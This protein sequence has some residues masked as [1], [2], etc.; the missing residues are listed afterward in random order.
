MKN[1]KIVL[2]GASI[3]LLTGCALGAKKLS[4]AEFKDIYDREIKVTAITDIKEA[5]APIS[6]KKEQRNIEPKTLV[7]ESYSIDVSKLEEFKVKDTL[8]NGLNLNYKQAATNYVT[9]EIVTSSGLKAFSDVEK[10]SLSTSYKLVNTVNDNAGELKFQ[11]IVET[12]LIKTDYLSAELDGSTGRIAAAKIII[13]DDIYGFGAETVVFDTFAMKVEQDEESTEEATDDA[14]SIVTSLAG[15]TWIL[16][17]ST[18]TYKDATVAFESNLDTT[19]SK[20][21]KIGTLTYQSVAHDLFIFEKGDGSYNFEI[22]ITETT[23]TPE[24]DQV[25]KTVAY[26]AASQ[27]DITAK[28]VPA[29]DEFLEQADVAAGSQVVL[30]KYNEGLTYVETRLDGSYQTEI[31]YRD[32]GIVFRCIEGDLYKEVKF[33][34]L[35]DKTNTRGIARIVERQGLKGNDIATYTFQGF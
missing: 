2:L 25:T 7:E 10:N 33:A 21:T 12:V 19:V 28:V 6:L 9:K 29:L 4:L 23:D 1:K 5:K 17:D 22:R 31:L 14:D 13:D 32:T 15:T 3:L 11:K 30:N 8:V 16:S 18:K 35:S 26:D 34:K 27:D 24:A 20:T